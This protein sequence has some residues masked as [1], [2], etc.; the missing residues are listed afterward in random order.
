M[1]PA[2]TLAAAL[3]LTP[4]T[5]PAAPA[6]TWHDCAT[7]DTAKRLQCAELPVPGA[8]LRLTRLPALDPAQR[9]GSLLVNP[10]GPGGSGADVVGYGGLGLATPE[11]AQLNQRF[12]IVGFDP[13][14]VGGSSPAIE[15]GPMHDPAVSRFPADDAGYERLVAHNREVGL[16]CSG[17]RNPDTGT[18]AEDVERI[19]L[20]LG[21]ER[22][23]WL[24]VSYGTEIGALYAARHPEHVRAMVLD[25]AVDHGLPMRRAIL[26]EAAATEHGLLRFAQWCAGP[27]VCGDDLLARYDDLMAH[28]APSRQL[29]RRATPEE[30]AAGVYAHLY[31]PQLWPRL[32]EAVRA[33]PEDAS[34]LTAA[35]PFTSPEYPAYRSVG[36]QD[37]PAPFT[38][39]ADLRRLADRVRQ[40][41]PHSWRY[42]EFWDFAT[43]CLGWP[44]PAENPPHPE[45]VRGAPPI[46]VVGG[47]HDPA[48]P[49]TWAHSLSTRIHG[50]VLLTHDEDGHTG[51]YNS[52]CVRRHEAA[53]LI[54]GTPGTTPQTRSLPC[55]KG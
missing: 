42:S 13:R 38:G 55:Q 44:V 4:V 24:G 9:I 45:P 35:M 6:L 10:G 11:F 37:F 32:A 18:V 2:L 39:P 43:G 47:E 22:I 27:G 5:A 31:F 20:A 28:G 30:L 49:L 17:P 19:R 12:D 53:Y 25:G 23:S 33:A 36:C 50:S 48:T 52:A 40:V 34:A 51:V 16:T 15:C 14:G 21:E 7:P 41:A 1:I 8:R 29:G 54:S 3:L 26:D 46:L